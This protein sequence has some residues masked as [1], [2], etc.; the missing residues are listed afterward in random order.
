MGLEV[1]TVF[2]KRNLVSKTPDYAVDFILAQDNGVASTL[3]QYV[4]VKT[5]HK[6]S[7]DL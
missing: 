6:L 2:Q 3:P 1:H 4:V 5:V 7:F